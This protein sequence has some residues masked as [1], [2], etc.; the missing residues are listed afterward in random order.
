MSNLHSL[1]RSVT[2]FE[3]TKIIGVRAE[4]L[5]RGS[6][7]LVTL[8]DDMKRHGMYDVKIVAEREYL[9]GVLPFD[10]KRVHCNGKDS[11]TFGTYEIRNPTQIIP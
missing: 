6:P 10:V 8:T 11:L 2:R 4:M 3:E 9:S 7:P 5:A 1:S